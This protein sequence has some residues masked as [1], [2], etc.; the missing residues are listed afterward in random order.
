MLQP[1][2][3]YSPGATALLAPCF[4]T[5]EQAAKVFR[6]GAK[7]QV[8]GTQL[9]K[10]FQQ[11]P[12]LE[13]MHHTAAQATTHETINR[14]CMERGTAYNILMSANTSD[15]KCEKT[16]QKLQLR[17]DLQLAG[18]IISAK[19]QGAKQDEAW[20]CMQSL[21][22]TMGVPQDTCLCLAL[23]VLELLPPSHWTSPSMHHF[24]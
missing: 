24:R 7:C 10:E 11:L 6:L 8:V 5:P 14:G 19:G 23:Q 21:L 18:F 16:L 9:A 22:D 2:V 13:A 12:G 17:Y 20:E 3:L 15:K 4:L 1:R